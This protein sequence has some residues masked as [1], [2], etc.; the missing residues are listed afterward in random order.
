MVWAELSLS[1]FLLV[2]ASLSI[3]LLFSINGT[4]SVFLSTHWLATSS[5]SGFFKRS[6]NAL[7]AFWRLRSAS[8]FS[9]PAL[10]SGKLIVIWDCEPGVTLYL[11]GGFLQI[12]IFT[13][14]LK[15][16]FAKIAMNGWIWDGK[17]L[18]YKWLNLQI[19]KTLK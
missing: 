12:L 8:E 18:K 7:R 3:K 10:T 19:V 16:V 14:K 11:I 9:I 6:F 17:K 15:I 13:N 1:E 5:S 4:D 2:V